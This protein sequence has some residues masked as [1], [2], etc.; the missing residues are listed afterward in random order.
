MC[1]EGFEKS[2]ELQRGVKG[3]AQVIVSS[4]GKSQRG[5]RARDKGQSSSNRN[6]L[7][8][9]VNCKAEVRTLKAEENEG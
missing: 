7:N 8:C 1:N 2:D 5:N 4:N 6:R 9:Q 3:A